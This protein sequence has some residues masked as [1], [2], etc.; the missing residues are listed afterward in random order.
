MI[1]RKVVIEFVKVYS[2]G[3]GEFDLGVMDFQAELSSANPTACAGGDNPR[4]C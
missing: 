2:V 1:H 4:S 3:D